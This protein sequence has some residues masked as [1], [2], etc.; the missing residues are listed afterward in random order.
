MNIEFGDFPCPNCGR[1]G[2]SGINCP[3]RIE[4]GSTS[5]KPPMT[6][7]PT[8]SLPAAPEMT[9]RD[10]FAGAAMFALMSSGAHLGEKETSRLAYKYADAMVKAREVENG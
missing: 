6:F 4:P 5:A 1:W 2:C 8:Y 7:A 3:G 10:W 9:R